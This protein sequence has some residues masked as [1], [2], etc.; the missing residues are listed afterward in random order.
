MNWFVVMDT[1]N[2]LEGMRA[3]LI[4]VIVTSLFYKLPVEMCRVLE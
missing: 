2:E 1:V 3:T 4:K